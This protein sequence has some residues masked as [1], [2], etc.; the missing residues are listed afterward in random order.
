MRGSWT[1]FVHGY[2]VVYCYIHVYGVI[3][4]T[5]ATTLGKSFIVIN[6]WSSDFEEWNVSTCLF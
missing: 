1:G 4:G 2:F 5:M 3:L 6:L